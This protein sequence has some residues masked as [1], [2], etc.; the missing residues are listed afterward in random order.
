MKILPDNS[1]CSNTH[2]FRGAGPVCRIA[3]MQTAKSYFHSLFAGLHAMQGIELLLLA[4]TAFI[5][6]VWWHGSILC[7]GLLFANFI[8]KSVCCA[9]IGNRYPKTARWGLIM[10][11]VL[12]AVY[13][14]SVVYSDDKVQAWQAVR[15][16]AAMPALALF[17]LLSDLSYLGRSRFRFIGYA[18]VAGCAGVFIYCAV[19]AAVVHAAGAAPFP[20]MADWCPP[21]QH[22]TYQ[23]MFYLMSLAFLYC[24]GVRHWQGWGLPQ[25]LAR[26]CIAAVLALFV[27][28][29]QS[30]SGVLT[31]AVLSLWWTVQL[32]F[33]YRRTAVGIVVGILGLGGV[34]LGGMLPGNGYCRLAKTVSQTVNRD[35]SDMRYEIWGS[36]VEVIRA[37]PVMGA[38]AGD[39]MAE[40]ERCHD[41][42]YGNRAHWKHYNAHNQF[43]DTWAAAGIGGLLCLAALFLLS[44]VC[45][46]RQR[47][48]NELL[49]TFLFIAGTAALVES[50]LERQMGLTFFFLFYGLLMLPGIA[51]N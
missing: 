22:H 12:F 37:N 5:I 1:R 24:D 43:L 3:V 30:R 51:E 14:A 36:A 44:A 10:S 28:L 31:L 49:L 15:Q 7:I 21:R 25:R 33:R 2:K 35:R 9:K 46:F 8:V 13:L 4:L 17:F 16:K 27:L 41:K 42:L 34:L 38:G 39:K 11:V 40:M 48:V 29:V 26:L 19:R 45:A 23:S 47:P 18:W 6:P 20:C 32:I 50:V